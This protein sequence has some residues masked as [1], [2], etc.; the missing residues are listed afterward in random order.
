MAGG[1]KHL[2]ELPPEGATSPPLIA[3]DDSFTGQD[4]GNQIDH[5][6]ASDRCLTARQQT[7]GPTL[8]N[9]ILHLPGK[10]S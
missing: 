7:F 6:S 1:V 3:E 4:I 9:S 5:V 2:D 10:I 8:Q